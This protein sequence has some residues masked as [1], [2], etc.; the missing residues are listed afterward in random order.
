MVDRLEAVP[1]SGLLG[2][3]EQVRVEHTLKPPVVSPWQPERNPL[4]L[5]VLGKLSEELGE[6]S[7][8]VARCMIQGI[9]EAEPVT[10]EANRER[11]ECELADVMAGIAVAMEQ[12]QLDRPHILLRAEA[13]VA[14]LKSWH[15]L[16]LEATR[17]FK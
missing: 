8:I 10:G 5:A 14:H 9:D 4:T 11:L 7:A 1:L 16:L 12:L 13:K 6:A 3:A 2:R 15:Q 17:I